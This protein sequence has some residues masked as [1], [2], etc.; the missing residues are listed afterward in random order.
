VKVRVNKIKGTQI[1]F[2]CENGDAICI[3]K[4]KAEPTLETTYDVELD[5]NGSISDL[6]IPNPEVGEYFI[7]AKLDYS[8]INGRL[9]SVES[10]GMGFLRLSDDCLIMIETGSARLSEG[11]WIKLEIHYSKLVIY[12]L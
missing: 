3:W 2:S 4:S 11:Q 9:E 7:H 1:F 6:Q 8:T 12:G 10:D 5:I